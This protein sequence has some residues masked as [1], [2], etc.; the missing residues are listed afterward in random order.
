MIEVL[1]DMGIKV[2]DVAN[3]DIIERGLNGDLQSRQLQAQKLVQM[4]R[5]A[6]IEV[7][8]SFAYETV[9][10]HPSHVHAA[11]RAVS[12]GFHVRLVFV[13]T[14]DPEINVARVRARVAKGGH[15]VPADKVRERWHRAMHESLI[16]MVQTAGESM[17][18]DNSDSGIRPAPRPIAHIMGKF[19]WF[20]AQ[21]D[22]RWPRPCLFDKLAATGL[23]V[24]KQRG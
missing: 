18:F 14:D 8:K 7:G 20:W 6:A 15:D 9:M 12:Q 2:E 21:P 1:D 23:Y 24:P 22:L 19:V 17:I 13:T 5:D 16:A 11:R 4:A 10:S 3:A